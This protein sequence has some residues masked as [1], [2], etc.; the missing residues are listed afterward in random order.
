MA[1]W[2]MIGLAA[3][4]LV[5]RLER[6]WAVRSWARDPVQVV[7]DTRTPRARFADEMCR[8]EDDRRPRRWAYALD[9][10]AEW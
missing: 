7:V 4:W 9:Q 1:E 10:A 2:L 6:L 8:R 3:L 5:E